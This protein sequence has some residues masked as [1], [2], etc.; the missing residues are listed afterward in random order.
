M[1]QK[2]YIKELIEDRDTFQRLYEK[3]IKEIIRLNNKK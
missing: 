1:T 2:T 3:A